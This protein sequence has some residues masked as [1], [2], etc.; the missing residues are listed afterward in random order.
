MSLG[1]LKKNSLTNR[2]ASSLHFLRTT[3]LLHR[4][5]GR[6]CSRTLATLPTETPIEL[7]YTSQIPSDDNETSGAIVLLHGLLGSSRNF[8]AHSRTFAEKL[9][10]P[11]YALDLRNHGSS[12]HVQPMTYSAMAA[13][14]TH[15]IHQHSLSDVSLIG[16]SM[17]GKVAMAVALESSLPASTLS[18]LIVVDIAPARGTM[19][20]EFHQHIKA[21]K[22]I[23]AAEVSQRKEALKIL[24]QYEKDPALCAFLL[25]NLIQKPNGSRFRIPLDLLGESATDIGYFPFTP[26]EAQWTGKTLFIKGSKSNF[27]NRHN[28][29]LAEK[30]FP[31]MRLETLDTH[32]WVHSE[33]PNEFSALVQDFVGPLGQ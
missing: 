6:P 10:R 8:A 31:N 3:S 1:Y 25:T 24:Q 9:Q 17:G 2:A 28:I 13:D 4:H 16:H 18:K 20:A 33:K 5:P 29:P 27:L 22:E 15:F 19:S 14:V 21:M 32:H 11:V 23:E 7:H 30:F 26:E 12:E